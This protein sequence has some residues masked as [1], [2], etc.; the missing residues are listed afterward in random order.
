MQ[1]NKNEGNQRTRQKSWGW[2]AGITSIAC[3][4]AN[5]V[6]ASVDPFPPLMPEAWSKT[7]AL[8]TKGGVKASTSPGDNRFW[9]SSGGLLRVDGARFMGSSDDLQTETSTAY[10][11]SVYIKTA[12]WNVKGGLGSEHLSYELRMKLDSGTAK[13]ADAMLNYKGFHPNSIL[14]IGQ[15]NPS[16]SLDNEN[17][18]SWQP[19]I[20]TATTSVFFPSS[21]LGAKYSMWWDHYAFKIAAV[22]PEHAS[23]SAP[24]NRGRDRIQY[25]ARAFY[26]PVNQPG[27]VYH[28]GAGVVL[29]EI[30]H[31]NYG[32]GDIK[33]FTMNAY[34]GAKARNTAT[35]VQLAEGD[36]TS[37]GDTSSVGM[38]AS[39]VK[40]F[41]LEFAREWGPVLLFG[42]Y[43]N[44]H[45][46]RPK[47][48]IMPSS[49]PAK[50]S[51]NFKS[52]YFQGS[53]LLTGESRQYTMADGEFSTIKPNHSYGAWEVAARYTYLD[54]N[55]R[56]I[57]GGSQH[58]LAFG[59][60][61]FY[62]EHLRVSV[63]YIRAHIH[64]AFIYTGPS[65]RKLDIVSGRVQVRW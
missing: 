5:S 33:R 16:F 24:A 35:L 38:R 13:M 26:A 43:Y 31:Q 34:P 56:D 61:W 64:P 17:S 12:D 57:L 20:D 48:T 49:S 50:D 29:R 25:S 58:D 63:N 65:V 3:V 8:N 46:K 32:A 36:V 23:T 2:V 47:P 39:V 27:D 30:E 7:E 21:G 19:F 9:F 44:M 45:V 6:F 51:V 15:V 18:T 53:W 1:R 40:Q 60:N 4:A 14:S 41:N 55:D 59:V 42:E 37:G 52:W 11:N 10:P 28:F 54:L 22:Q 62:S